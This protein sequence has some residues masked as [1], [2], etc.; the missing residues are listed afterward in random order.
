MKDYVKNDYYRWKKTRQKKSKDSRE[1]DLQRA[2]EVKQ[3]QAEIDEQERLAT[4]S[5][6]DQIAQEDSKRRAAVQQQE[7]QYWGQ[8]EQE[9]FTPPSQRKA[10]ITPHEEYE[11]PSPP[12]MNKPPPPPK[13]NNGPPPPPPNLKAPG[14]PPGGRG[15]APPPPPPSG[16][17]PQSTPERG[18]LLDSIQSFSKFALRPTQTNDR[19]GPMVD[20]KDEGGSSSH[21]Q[22]G[23]GAGRGAPKGG[24]QNQLA[25]AL[26]NRGGKRY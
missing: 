12:Q 25:A 11:I 20:S 16:D 7:Q 26:A 13:Q 19:S 1:I 10:A 23:G 22:G 9:E 3:R 8:R 5:H 21:H 6:R 4:K 18:A 14:K 24:V 15:P 17:L 2:R